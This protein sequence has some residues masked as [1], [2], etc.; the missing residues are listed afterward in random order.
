MAKKNNPPIITYTEILARA[1]QSIGQ[2]IESWRNRCK[3]LPDGDRILAAAT[4]DLEAK[5]D[6]VKEL[7][8]IETGSD[9]E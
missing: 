6:A 9:Y 4:E 2:E 7:Y 1:I 8:R 5:L 3:G